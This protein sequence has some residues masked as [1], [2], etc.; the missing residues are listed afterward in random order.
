[1]ITRL[2]SF[3]LL[4]IYFNKRR[5]TLN[6]NFLRNS[7]DK[8]GYSIV[9]VCR[10]DVAEMEAHLSQ[11]PFVVLQIVEVEFRPLATPFREGE[12]AVQR[13]LV[14]TPVAVVVIVVVTNLVS[15]QGVVRCRRVTS[16][17]FGSAYAT[18]VPRGGGRPRPQRGLCGIMRQTGRFPSVTF[19]AE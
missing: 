10:K 16:T 19:A 13:P 14:F 2:C 1:M 12:G 9:A 5:K 3:P 7:Q 6:E 11:E 15:S 18:L 8:V 4:Q 17:D